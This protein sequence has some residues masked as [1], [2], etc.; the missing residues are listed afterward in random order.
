[1]GYVFNPFTG[2]FDYTSPGVSDHESLTGLQGGTTGQHV[3]LT[4][5]EYNWLYGQL[6]GHTYMTSGAETI[7]KTTLDTNGHPAW[8]D[9][10]THVGGGNVPSVR[11]DSTAFAQ[12]DVIRLLEVDPGAFTI[13]LGTFFISSLAYTTVATEGDIPG[14]PFGQYFVT[15]TSHYYLYS[16]AAG[17][18][19]SLYY[20]GGG[21]WKLAQQSFLNFMSGQL[22]WAKVDKT[23]AVPSD[24]GAANSAGDAAQAFIVST[25]NGLTPTAL[26]TGFS[27]AGGTTSKTLTVDETVSM[28]SKAPQDSPTFT[29]AT[30]FSGFSPALVSTTTDGYLATAYD[31]TAGAGCQNIFRRAQGTV[32][33]PTAVASGQG[34]GS[35]SF[36]GHTGSGFA[37]SKGLIT[38]AAT[39][40]WSTTANGTNF[41]FMTTANTTTNLTTRLTIGNTG[42]LTSP[43]TYANTAATSANVW[44]DS[45]GNL[46]R[47]SSS[48]RYKDPVEDITTE[49]SSRIYQLRPVWYRSLCEADRRDWSWYGLIAEEVALVEPRLVTWGYRDYKE[50]K[51]GDSVTIVPDTD[52]PLIPEGV[53]YDRLTVLLLKEVAL[54]KA[55]I[56][57]LEAV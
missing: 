40:N 39:E 47:N 46:G 13:D 23:G 49:Y 30:T 38:C 43:A 20:L 32:S 7:D 25:I 22:A 52:S 48:I 21:Q 56:E 5:D 12:G 33:S 51:E 53:M 26:A 4:D 35:L 19:V 2:T 24:I 16:G 9:L 34:L 17:D 1:M 3:H 41:V 6:P 28:S 8:L 42:I 45:S 36:R 27:I 11:L 29:T 44:V 55:R 57:A 54:L 10:I 18:Y 37:G 14:S 31:S 15:A 50:I